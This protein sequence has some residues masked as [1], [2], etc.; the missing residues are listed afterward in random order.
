MPAFVAIADD[1]RLLREALATLINKFDQYEVLFTAENGLDLLDQ[2]QQSKQVPDVALVDSL[3]PKMD[4]I[5]T[6]AQ[7]QQLY[8]SIR[9]L[10]L[11][12]I[13]QEEPIRQMLRNG[14][15]GYLLKGCRSEELR[16]ALDDVMRT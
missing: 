16:Q 15:R 8:P 7:L 3:M 14:A 1:H 4:G 11:F 5:E 10:G 13:D 9:V 2:I 12:I 6:T